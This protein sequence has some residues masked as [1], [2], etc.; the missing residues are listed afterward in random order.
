MPDE[1]SVQLGKREDLVQLGKLIE[2][3][4]R[5]A[6]LSASEVAASAGISPAYMRTLERGLNP[7]TQR[8]SRPA[9]DPLLGIALAIDQD[10]K[11]WLALAGYAEHLADTRSMPARGGVDDHLRSVQESAKLLNKRSPFMAAQALDVLKRLSKEFAMAA[12]G[13]VLCGPKEEPTLTQAAVAACDQHL[14]AVSY[15]DEGWWNSSSGDRY[16]EH[17][18]LLRQRDVEMTRIF[19]VGNVGVEALLPTL[20]RHVQ[21]GISTYVIDPEIVDEQQWRDVVIYDDTILRVANPVDS[22]DY[23]R[24]TARF[25][26]DP[27]QVQVALLDFEDLRTIALADG[28]DAERVLAKYQGRR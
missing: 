14:R 27:S 11:P 17:H 15:Q 21:L 1:D 8:P 7:K 5:A 28:G 4:R 24:K 3:A 25:T 19:L 20:E 18:D 22:D 12:G 2:A 23:D 10:P 16:L 13:T 9:L 26:D 6:G